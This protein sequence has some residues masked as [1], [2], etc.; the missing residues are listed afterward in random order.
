MSEQLT[1]KEVLEYI[2][3]M[4]SAG[5]ITYKQIL[6]E[7]LTEEV[8]EKLGKIV[9]CDGERSDDGDHDT[10]FRRVQFEKCPEYFEGCGYYSSDWGIDFSYC[11]ELYCVEEKEVMVK[12]WVHKKF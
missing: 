2:K 5:K 6:N 8:E 1:G 9:Y 10:Y 3:Q 4:V 11:D 12:Q 7:D